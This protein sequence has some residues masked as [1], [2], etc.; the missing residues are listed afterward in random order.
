MNLVWEITLAI[1]LSVAGNL[2]TPIASRYLEAGSTVIKTS[3]RK[4]SLYRY[5]R[6]KRL[7][8]D[9]TYREMYVVRRMLTVVSGYSACLLF[10]LLVVFEQTA[11]TPEM[12]LRATD[13]IARVLLL[14]L[15]FLSVGL[16]TLGFTTYQSLAADTHALGR[17]EEY[18]AA[19]REK[20]GAEVLAALKPPVSKV[21]WR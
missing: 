12:Q 20:Y 10:L 15:G 19:M 17:W 14:I 2:V 7:H 1:I 6:R 9:Q 18:D 8:D 11:W 5:S 4:S 13:G 16:F 3:N 21:Q